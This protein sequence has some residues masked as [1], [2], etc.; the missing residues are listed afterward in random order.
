MRLDREELA[1]Q[2]ERDRDGL[3]D[4]VWAVAPCLRLPPRRRLDVR[5]RLPWLRRRGSAPEV[6][7][8]LER[9]ELAAQAERNRNGLHDAVLAVGSA[10][11]A[12]PKT[13]RAHLL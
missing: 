12:A 3:H 2:A 4:A 11:L 7:K 10:P 8:R 9:E 5:P 1:A 13:V 6:A